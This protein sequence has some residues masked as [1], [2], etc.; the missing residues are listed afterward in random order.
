MALKDP[1]IKRAFLDLVVTAKKKFPFKLWN[2][3]IMDN[4]ID[5]LI[6]PEKGVSLSKIMQWI[7]CNSAKQWNKAHNTKGHLWGDRFSSQIVE[8]EEDFECVSAC[9]DRNPVKAKLVWHEI[10]WEFGGLS[11]WL[12]GIDGIIGLL[13]ECFG[14]R[15]SFS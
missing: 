10:D 4:S 7:K 8:D 14:R 9:I 13:D 15:L 2:F 1:D 12:R 5:F 6:K 11:Y 3:T